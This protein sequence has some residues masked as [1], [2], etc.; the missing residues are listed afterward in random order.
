MERHFG[1][2]QLEEQSGTGAIERGIPYWRAATTGVV[3][4]VTGSARGVASWTL[5]SSSSASSGTASAATSPR[6]SPISS[7]ARVSRMSPCSA[8]VSL[9]GLCLHDAFF[10]S[11]LRKARELR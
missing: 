5:T 4:K 7:K 2:L 6:L 11:L 9:F 10:F 8:R 3:A 1:I